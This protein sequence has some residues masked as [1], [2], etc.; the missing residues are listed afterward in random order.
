MTSSGAMLAMPQMVPAPAGGDRAGDVNLV[1]DGDGELGGGGTECLELLEV[2]AG[3]FQPSNHPAVALA[4]IRGDAGRDRNTRDLRDMIEVG[5]QAIVG[6]AVEDRR[7]GI[8]DAFRAD[9]AV[10]V[11]RQQQHVTQAE[12]EY[13]ARQCD[14]IADRGEAAADSNSFRRHA[15]LEHGCNG[16]DAFGDVERGALAGGAEQHDTVDALAEELLGVSGELC[17]VHAAVGCQR[18]S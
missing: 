3:V 17:G 12:A 7:K 14:A 9:A 18:R 11:R 16:R 2:A 8:F 10:E 6:D 5:T 15:G 1:A 4:Q 13:G